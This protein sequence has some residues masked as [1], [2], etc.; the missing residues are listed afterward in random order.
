MQCNQGVLMKKFWVDT[1]AAINES[2]TYRHTPS[3]LA[4]SAFFYMQSIGHFL[5]DST[6]YTKR[7]GYRSILLIYTASGNGR[8]YYRGRE[9]NLKAGQVLLMDCYDYQEY[10]TEKNGTWEIKWLHF[11]GNASQEYF[12]MIYDKYGAVIDLQKSSSI[13]PILD[14]ILQTADKCGFLLEARIS[15][16]ITQVLTELLLAGNDCEKHYDIKAL[17]ERVQMALEYVDENYANSI[18]LSELASHSCCSDYHFLRLFK[19]ITGYSPYEYIVKYRVNKAKSLLKN[20]DKSIDE[21]AECVG[22]RSTSNFIQTFKKLEEITPL[23]YRK[24]CN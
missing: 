22:F 12:N 10:F 6:Y 21:I 2:N 23:K 8:A 5:C 7:E 11:Y 1:N 18:S 4:K 13:P 24:Y 17:N 19:K 14:E 9:Y 20:S 15:M 3:L 16:L